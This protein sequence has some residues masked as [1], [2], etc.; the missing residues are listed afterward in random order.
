MSQNPN[1]AE[2]NHCAKP[3]KRGLLATGG[4]LA[5]LHL[6]C[7]A[8]WLFGA[9]GLGGAAALWCGH[10]SAESREDFGVSLARL[11]K[12]PNEK[13]VFDSERNTAAAEL[14]LKVQPQ[15]REVQAAKERDAN[16]A[17]VQT[18][19]LKD[20]NERISVVVCLN[21]ALCP[22]S[23]PQI[24][25]VGTLSDLQRPERWQGQHEILKVLLEND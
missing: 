23:E 17:P 18:V 7:G 14:L 3:I 19:F 21:G 1:T 15:F 2:P 8:G 5:L 25:E 6:P 12:V 16:G 11:A 9:L 13:V 22:C 24:Y 4:A 10:Q 20:S